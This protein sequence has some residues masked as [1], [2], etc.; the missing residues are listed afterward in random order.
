VPPQPMA[1]AAGKNKDAPKN[2][3][4]ATLGFDEE[5]WQAADKL[6]GNLDAADYKHVVLGL[7]FL[8][9]ISDACEERPLTLATLC[10]EPKSEYFVSDPA[11]GMR[12]WRTVTSTSPPTSSPQDSW[13]VAPWPSWASSPRR[14]L[15]GRYAVAAA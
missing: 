12:P 13:H 5:L 3:N 6:R 11:S 10:V 15:E 7:I 1:G 9:Y 4:G 8:K 2:G 14:R